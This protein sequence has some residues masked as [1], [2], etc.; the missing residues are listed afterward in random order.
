LI[1]LG[2]LQIQVDNGDTQRATINWQF[3]SIDARTKLK[4]L[5]P[6]ISKSA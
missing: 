5:C 3:T 2:R 1:L 4:R 6:V